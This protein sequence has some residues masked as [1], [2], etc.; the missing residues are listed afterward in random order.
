VLRQPSIGTSSVGMPCFEFAVGAGV[1]AGMAM[2][3]K[4]LPKVFGAARSQETCRQV[5]AGEGKES[6]LEKELIHSQG[7]ES[8][9]S[10][11]TLSGA[12]VDSTKA[13]HD[14]QCK[15]PEKTTEVEFEGKT[16]QA[17]L[18]TLRAVAARCEA[19][20]Q[21]VR[22]LEL[23]RESMH[24]EVEKDAKARAELEILRVRVDKLTVERDTAVA[25]HQESVRQVRSLEEEQESL[26]K[27]LAMNKIKR[28]DSLKSI[29]QSLSDINSQIDAVQASWTPW[30]EIANMREKVASIQ[31]NAASE[32]EDELLHGA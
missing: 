7:H 28:K 20:E 8:Q 1:G 21:R 6:A 29:S 17:E 24:E 12:K 11:Q 16:V 32:D 26:Q 18:E 9:A 2:T 22:T 10:M 13:E 3:G 30:Q 5:E 25:Q 27:E 14:T 4:S 23:E 31:Q 15:T 19:A